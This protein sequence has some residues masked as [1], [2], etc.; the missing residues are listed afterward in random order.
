MKSRKSIYILITVF[1][2]LCGG[3]KNSRLRRESIY[4]HGYYKTGR[5]V[6]GGIYTDHQLQADLSLSPV[7]QFLI[8][9][10]IQ[11]LQHVLVFSSFDRL[12]P[13]RFACVVFFSF[14]EVTFAISGGHLL[15]GGRNILGSRR[16][17]FTFLSAFGT[18]HQK[19]LSQVPLVLGT[20]VLVPFRP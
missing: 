4:E 5:S 17:L 12:E 18:G 16:F 10:K 19:R 8:G 3:Q 15:F 11:K 9:K 20:I 7:K 1:N 2:V 6:R 14:G 13:N